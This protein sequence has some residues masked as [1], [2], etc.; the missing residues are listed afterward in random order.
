MTEKRPPGRPRKLDV[1]QKVV[2]VRVHNSTHKRIITIAK[3]EGKEMADLVREILDTALD[4][5]DS[6]SAKGPRASSDKAHRKKSTE[7]PRSDHRDDGKR[8]G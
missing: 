6:T 2:H 4:Q 3:Q 8:A 5:Y 1:D 7:E